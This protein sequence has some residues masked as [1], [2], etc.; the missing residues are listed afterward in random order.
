MPRMRRAGAGLPAL[1][2]ISSPSWRDA[3]GG[4]H[5]P[6]LVA[7]A[8]AGQSQ[9][10]E[11]AASSRECECEPQPSCCVSGESQA[12]CEAWIVKDV[13]QGRLL[14]QEPYA[15]FLTYLRRTDRKWELRHHALAYVEASLATDAC[16]AMPHEPNLLTQ[17]TTPLGDCT[18]GLL[19][20]VMQRYSYYLDRGTFTSERLQ[21]VNR[22]S[23]ADAVLGTPRS[24]WIACARSQ[25]DIVASSL[26]RW[27]VQDTMSDM[28]K[29]LESQAVTLSRQ[30]RAWIGPVLIVNIAF[31]VLICLQVNKK[32]IVE[33][34]KKL[35]IA[36]VRTSVAERKATEEVGH[37]HTS[38]GVMEV[39]SRTSTPLA[40]PKFDRTMSAP[41]HAEAG[42]MWRPTVGFT[43]SMPEKPPSPRFLMP[44]DAG[45][46]R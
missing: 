34:M 46:V 32:N 4:W 27:Q 19:Y 33:G 26:A 10:L 37:R 35:P 45:T 30:D 38:D 43:Q 20:D 40:L 31:V 12:R 7:S 2:A 14:G 36:A 25:A 44:P 21:R 24:R 9:F 22:Q 8:S 11:R 39:A 28:Q 3:S 29:E 18:D 23:E 5:G 41:D 17:V 13:L 16:A 42:R 1:L 15:E 6:L